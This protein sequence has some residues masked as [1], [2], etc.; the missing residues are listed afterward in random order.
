[1][2]T[3]VFKSD[4]YRLFCHQTPCIDPAASRS[5]ARHVL[6]IR[7]QKMCIYIYIPRDPSTFSDGDRRH[8]YVGMEG[9]S[10]F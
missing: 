5:G 9:P 10:T 4:L 6:P 7:T 1:M 8:S 2:Q 3:V